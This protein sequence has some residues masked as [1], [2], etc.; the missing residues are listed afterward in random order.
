[1]RASNLNCN[2]ISCSDDRLSMAGDEQIVLEEGRL[3]WNKIFKLFKCDRLL[4][5]LPDGVLRKVG[6]DE[7]PGFRHEVI[8]VEFIAYLVGRDLYWSRDTFLQHQ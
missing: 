7:L 4:K 3:H 8:F 5:E 2:F 1:M 6:E